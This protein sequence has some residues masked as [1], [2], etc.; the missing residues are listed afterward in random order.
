MNDTATNA[1]PLTVNLESI[2][3]WKFNVYA[4]LA[5]NRLKEE[6]QQT[7]NPQSGLDENL[8]VI[9]QGYMFSITLLTGFMYGLFEFL[10]FKNDIWFY[11]TKTNRIGISVNSIVI[12]IVIQAILFSYMMD[13]SNNAIRGCIQLTHLCVNVWKLNHVWLHEYEWMIEQGSNFR[14]T[15]KVV[16]VTTKGKY[17]S[18][19]QGETRT[20]QLDAIA[21]RFLALIALPIFIVYNAYH[22]YYHYNMLIYHQLENMCIEEW[23]KK[24]IANGIVNFLSIFEPFMVIGPQVYINY[25][26]NTVNHVSL[27]TMIYKNINIVVGKFN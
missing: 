7:N 19:E 12:H 20:Q 11:K 14:F 21:L 27:N 17:K 5:N 3:V 25:K 22:Y 24:V 2:N 16:H 13:F 23:T 18:I 15:V 9:N 4:V 10:A 1:L 8:S 6:S 26:M